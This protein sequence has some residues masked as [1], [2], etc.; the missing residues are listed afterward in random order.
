MKRKIWVRPGKTQSVAGI[1]IGIVFLLIG[2]FMV[3]PT[4]G[5]F[6]LLWTRYS[7]YYASHEFI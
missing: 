7:S 4:F 1:I 6:G 2:I 5:P 3:I